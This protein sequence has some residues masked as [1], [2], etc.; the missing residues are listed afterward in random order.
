MRKTSAILL[1]L[2][3]LALA[4][5]ILAGPAAAAPH[6]VI[7]GKE[8]T[9]TEKTTGTGG[10]AVLKSK[11]GTSTLTITCK[12]SKTT[13]TIEAGGKTTIIITFEECSITTT[14]NSTCLV[15]VTLVT[16]TIIDQLV[17]TGTTIVD[18]FT[19]VTVE[20]L[21]IQITITNCALEGK[22]KVKGKQTASLP[23][24]STEATTHEV[25][26]SSGGSSLKFG[27]EVAT[28]EGTQTIKLESGKKYSMAK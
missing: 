8:V 27:T 1:G 22:F 15:S 23:S 6:F 20:E 11:I 28:F 7:E 24:Q 5:A 13:G 21:F 18:V 2:V 14:P 12:K 10:V 16:V 4:G 26:A 9:A 3:A 25:V 19:G 17:D